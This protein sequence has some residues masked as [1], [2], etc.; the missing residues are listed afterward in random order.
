MTLTEKIAKLKESE[1]IKLVFNGK[2]LGLRVKFFSLEHERFLYYDFSLD[3]VKDAEM[4]NF[5][6]SVKNMRSAELHRDGAGLLVTD[7][8]IKHKIIIQEFESEEDT[9]RILRLL[10]EVYK[11]KAG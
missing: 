11:S 2:T 7:D 8:E 5:V 6:K 3:T 9:A 10:S 4:R 1:L